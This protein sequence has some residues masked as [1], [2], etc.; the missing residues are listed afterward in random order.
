M[1]TE[2]SKFR[3][4]VFVTAG[5]LILLAVVFM[6][7]ASR[8]LQ[9]TRTYATY[10]R[11]SVQGLEINAPVKFR[12]LNVGRVSAI[13]IAPDGKLIE[14]LM[15]I[16]Q[17]RF[18]PKKAHIIMQRSANISGMK[19]L[20]V[21][22]REGREQLSPTLAFTSTY[23]VIPSYPSAQITEI[24]DTIKKQFDDIDARGISMGITTVL[25][26]VNELLDRGRWEPIVS[27]THVA[28]EALGMIS[29]EVQAYVAMGAL[30]NLVTNATLASQH[31]RALS[32]RLD[33]ERIETLLQ[34]LTELVARLNQIAYTTESS[35]DPVL[36][37][38]QR[39][40]ANL[41]S[42]TEQ[43]KTRPS[44]TLFG[45]PTKEQQQP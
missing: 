40:A 16:D 39:S 29:S 19:Y 11:E 10:F 7:G 5:A 44:Q 26:R 20:E 27:N 18:K 21:E 32:A 6:F 3:V 31:L 2:A 30:S 38:L 36:Q 45:S 37:D 43:L 14:V 34:E 42:F 15:Q 4:G 22:M 23:P 17:E 1:A 41:R 25:A 13:R 24:L 9:E 8:Y 12:G 28:A 35:F 33:N